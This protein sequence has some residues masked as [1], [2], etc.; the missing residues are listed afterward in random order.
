MNPGKLDRRVTF[1]SLA[2]TAGAAGGVIETYTAGDTVWA[3]KIEQGTREFRAA[4]AI[5]AEVTRA[6]RVRYRSDIT[7]KHRLT[8]GG[9]T[10]DILGTVEEGRGE[11]L[12]IGCKYTEGK[13]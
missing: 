1:L 7:P 11:F 2:V 4:S 5:H 10:H 9:V 12:L 8:F 3:E 6:F 13:A